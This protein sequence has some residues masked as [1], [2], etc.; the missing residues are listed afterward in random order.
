MTG[1]FGGLS[2]RAAEGPGVAADTGT[3]GTEL[4]GLPEV[5]CPEN[6]TACPEASIAFKRSV[7]FC[8]ASM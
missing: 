7:Y 6:S 3:V 8:R 2:A 1:S 5:A 4:G